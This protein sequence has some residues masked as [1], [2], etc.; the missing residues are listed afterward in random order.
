MVA[1]SKKIITLALYL[2]TP[3]S[4]RIVC[5]SSCCKTSLLNMSSASKGEVTAMHDARVIQELQHVHQILKQQVSTIRELQQEVKD[6][7]ANNQ[8]STSLRLGQYTNNHALTPS[9]QTFLDMLPRELLSQIFEEVAEE[10]NIQDACSSRS[11]SGLMHCPKTMAVSRHFAREFA[12]AFYS[13]T[14]F[15]LRL[16][17]EKMV[18]GWLPLTNFERFLKLAG[19]EL[20][21]LIKNL[22]CSTQIGASSTW[23]HMFSKLSA[24]L[25][26]SS[27]Q[28]TRN[29]AIT[30]VPV[31]GVEISK[32]AIRFMM[33]IHTQL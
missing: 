18:E 28:P 17:R 7:A 8:L 4:N 3:F 31:D 13:E 29:T 9:K 10:Y 22:E 5:V 24:D 15:N 33:P 6:L 21:P 11:W 2:G 14:Y 32:I 20:L 30:S 25:D 1:H 19:R 26:R 27:L 23:K 12:V 16:H